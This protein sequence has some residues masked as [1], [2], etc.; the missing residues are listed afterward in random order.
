MEYHKK[1]K[2]PTKNDKN[3]VNIQ[4]VFVHIHC[5]TGTCNAKKASVEYLELLLQQQSK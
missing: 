4:F 5:Y 2:Q 1:I 3:Q